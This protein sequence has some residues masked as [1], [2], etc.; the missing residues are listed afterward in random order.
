MRKWQLVTLA[1]GVAVVGAPTGASAVELEPGRMVIYE[2]GR[3]VPQS[4]LVDLGDPG[5][6][7]GEV[8]SGNPRIAARVDH[9]RDGVTAGVFQATR[10]RIRIHFPF[11]EH[12]TIT[13]GTV[14]LTDAGGQRRTLRPGDSYLIR[15]GST[16]LWEVRGARVQKTFFNRVEATDRP[17]PMRIYD[18]HD[19]VPQSDLTDLGD[20]G[21]LGGVV[22]SGNPRIAARVDDVNGPFTAGIFQAT[23]GDVQIGFPFTEHATILSRSVTLTDQTG[24]RRRL[25]VGDSYLIRRSSSI[26]WQVSRPLVQKSFFNVVE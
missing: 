26:L 1:V 16:I 21:G 18:A 13:S 15:Q 5:A 19:E 10:G 2:A 17:G 4:Q 6:L 3:S 9:Q 24:T 12:A 25:G 7:G 20:P 23:R 14:T 11:T 22:L 8:L